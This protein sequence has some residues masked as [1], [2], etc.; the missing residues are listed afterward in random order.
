MDTLDK[1]DKY[2][3]ES[4]KIITLLPE[5]EWNIPDWAQTHIR[6]S[7]FNKKMRSAFFENIGKKVEIISTEKLK[8]LNRYMVKDDKG[9]KFY[10][11]EGMFK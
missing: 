7:Q 5:N 10:V 8:E 3:S 1:I 2:L 9:R 4:K 11:W 6:N